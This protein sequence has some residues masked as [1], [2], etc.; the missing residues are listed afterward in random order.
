M[1]CSSFRTCEFELDRVY[2]VVQI[3]GDKFRVGKARSNAPLASEGS[4]TLEELQL[5]LGALVIQSYP[6]ISQLFQ[7]DTTPLAGRAWWLCGAAYVPRHVTYASTEFTAQ[8]SGM[9]ILPKP[10]V[11]CSLSTVVEGGTT[12]AL[13]VGKVLDLQTF[14]KSFKAASFEPER[15][16]LIFWFDAGPLAPCKGSGKFQ[17]TYDMDDSDH[18]ADEERQMGRWPRRLLHVPSMTSFPW[19]PGN[20]Y[21]NV[22]EPKYNILTYTWGRW[23]LRDNDEHAGEVESVVIAG[24]PWDIPKISPGHFTADQFLSVIRGITRPL[25]GRALPGVDFVWLDIACINQRDNEPES[26][27]E[28][29]RQADIFRGATACFAWL[30]T[31]E[32]SD[33]LQSV[34]SMQDALADL[35]IPA[36]FRTRK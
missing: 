31:I 22:V 18:L 27:A 7:H 13:F 30:T 35:K 12:W 14:V 33:L 4:F 16:N 26:A 32:E 1:T 20:V 9:S 19:Q 8:I 5:E 10:N 24:V 21:G 15:S 36:K 28:V 11:Q 2:G 6:D 34:Q 23:R 25:D 29:G 17:R 3:F